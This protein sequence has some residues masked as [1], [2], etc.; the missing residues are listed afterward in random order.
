MQNNTE[1]VTKVAYMYYIDNLPQSKIASLLN[2]SNSTVSRL[3]QTA[4]DRGIVKI[5]I[6]TLNT[7]CYSLEKLLKE[8]FHIEEAIVVPSY[9]A[10]EENILKVL[11]E[12][13]MNYL[14]QNIQEG[15]TVAFSMGKT[16]SEVANC[17]EV[18]EKVDCNIVPITGGLGQVKSELHSNDICRR[19]ADKFGGTAYPLYAPA[20]VG[21]E[22]LKNAIITDPMIQSVFKMGLNADIT[23]VGVGNVTDSTFIDLGIISKEEAKIMENDGVIGDIGSWFFDKKGNILNLDIHKRVVGPDFSKLSEQS[24]VVLI[25][26]TNEKKEVIKAALQGNWV[27]VLITCENVAQYLLE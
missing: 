3:I 1:L 19:I 24:K 8:K 13:G 5:E 20:I 25:S 14:K 4:R 27:D 23:V 17:L 9:S 16:L 10:I 12:A 15:M 21:N 26:G 11:G 7:R 22:E 18:D 6:Q 2:I